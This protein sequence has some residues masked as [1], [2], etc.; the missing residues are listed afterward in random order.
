MIL[1]E[2]FC[3]VCG[4]YIFSEQN[5][6]EICPICGWEDDSLQLKNPDYDGGANN[7]SLNDFRK[8]W[9]ESQVD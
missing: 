8:R 6:F 3:P 4:K 7:E 9:L 5:S 2:H 1:S